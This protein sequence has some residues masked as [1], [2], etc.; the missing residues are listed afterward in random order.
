MAFGKL[1][2]QEWILKVIARCNIPRQDIY[3]KT[4]LNDYETFVQH[5]GLGV[6]LTLY[7]YTTQF[8]PE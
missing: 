2:I 3:K 4:L 5:K 8:Y 1:H 7:Q 6:R